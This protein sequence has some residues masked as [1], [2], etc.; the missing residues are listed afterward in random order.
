LIPGPQV[1]LL[2]GRL[3]VWPLLRCEWSCLAKLFEQIYLVSLLIETA[4]PSKPGP[5]Q[6]A[7]LAGRLP[8]W[9]CLAA[10]PWRSSCLAQP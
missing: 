3:P 10:H 6:M 1:A 9:R 8:T 5:L 7:L 2:A 4:K